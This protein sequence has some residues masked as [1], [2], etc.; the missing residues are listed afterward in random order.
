MHLRTRLQQNR[1][2][3]AADRGCAVQTDVAMVCK[4]LRPRV[5]QLQR[6]GVLAPVVPPAPIPAPQPPH[7]MAEAVAF[8][9]RLTRMPSWPEAL[10]W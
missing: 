10:E 8:G 1:T 3:A 2:G 4:I 9:R 5:P 7:P 6:L